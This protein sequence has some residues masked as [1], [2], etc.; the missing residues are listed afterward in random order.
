MQ[1]SEPAETRAH[2]VRPVEIEDAQQ[3]IDLQN[4]VFGAKRTILNWNWKALENPYAQKVASVIESDAKIVAY[5]GVVGI[6]LN[7]SGRPILCGQSTDTVVHPELRNQRLFKQ[8]MELA[9]ELMIKAG[10]KFAFGFPNDQ[11]LPVNIHHANALPIAFAK[12]YFKKLSLASQLKARLKLSWLAYALDLPFVLLVRLACAAK[13]FTLR[14]RLSGSAV[15]SRSDQ[16]DPNY[17]ALWNVLKTQEIISLWKDAAYLKWRY[18]QHPT[19]K[20]Q[21]FHCYHDGKLVGMANVLKRRNMLVVCE[22]AVLN[23]SV[24]IGQLLLNDICRYCREQGLDGVSF[25]GHDRGF[26]GQVFSS[27]KYDPCRD[28]T[29][30]GR[31]FVTDDRLCQ[32]LHNAGNWSLTSGDT[33]EFY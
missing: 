4:L 16:V 13:E 18:D 19:R 9:C 2:I 33:D 10:I 27:F 14:Q 3:V 15:L 21:Y 31:M 26:F 32:L 28:L 8:S 22:L 23:K 11:A 6:N 24:I 30:V 29:L 25:Y 5:Y 17:D 12:Y 1:E 20:A 7:L